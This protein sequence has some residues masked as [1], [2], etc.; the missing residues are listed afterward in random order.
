[1]RMLVI[2]GLAGLA[3]CVSASPITEGFLSPSGEQAYLIRCGGALMSMASCQTEARKLCGGNYREINRSIEV[4]QDAPIPTESRQI[5][6]V[7][8]P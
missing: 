8:A 1:M 3:S 5:E 7:C 4:R 2:V 6:I